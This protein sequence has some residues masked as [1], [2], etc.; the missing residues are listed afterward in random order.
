MKWDA[1]TVR[2][3]TRL[4]FYLAT[5]SDASS[6]YCTRETMKKELEEHPQN[7]TDGNSIENTFQMTTSQYISSHPIPLNH[8]H[9]YLSLLS[10]I[11]NP[12]SF[13]DQRVCFHF[14]E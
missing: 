3:A 11:T 10:Q 4:N 14:Q 5:L 7:C 12:F 9:K 1:L 13:I 8:R 2:I 6:S